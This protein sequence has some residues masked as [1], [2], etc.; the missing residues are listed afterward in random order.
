MLVASLAL[1]LSATKAIAAAR[2]TNSAAANGRITL[3]WN[4]RGTLETAAALTGQW[5]ALG[6][7]A[8]PYTATL[9]GSPAFFRLNQTVDASTLQRKVLCGYQGWFR[10][11][12]DGG[13]QW[14]Q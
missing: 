2:L 8:S 7:A 9:T 1:S 3:T 14:A 11:P 4:G 13:S 10:C 6:N 5:R 12:G